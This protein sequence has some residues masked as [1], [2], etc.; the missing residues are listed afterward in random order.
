M[1]A[2][3]FAAAF[4]AAAVL[5]AWSRPQGAAVAVRL[6]TAFTC[7]APQVGCVFLA[8]I[9]RTTGG[10]WAVGLRPFIGAGVALLP[11]T[12]ALSA[13]LM[14]LLPLGAPRAFAPVLA[15]DGVPMLAARAVLYGILFFWIR[16][17]LAPGLGS[18]VRPL[19]NPRPWVGPVGLIL[20][21][22]ALTLVADDWLE[23]M[24]PGWHSTAFALV[25]MC[26]QTVAG[27]ALCL[28]GALGGGARPASRGVAGRNYGND[29]G[30]LLL[31]TTVFYTY[32]AFAQFLII[33]AGNLPHEI[34]WYLRREQGGWQFVMPAAALFGFAVPF[35]L[36]LS[37]RV[38]ASVAGLAWTSSIVL[39]A[40]LPTSPGS[41]CPPSVRLRRPQPC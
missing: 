2:I 40:S 7:L 36:L 10:Q 14:F 13:P 21:F 29:W 15:Y 8:L 39:E 23:S 11:W 28:L 27:L 19:D 24:E 12:W 20:M 34:S 26:A 30:N 38:K 35:C 31:A 1:R 37:R 32:V 4:A 3:G 33:W 5:L 22:F 9:H 18:D 25:W 41:S 16:S 17:A 6:A